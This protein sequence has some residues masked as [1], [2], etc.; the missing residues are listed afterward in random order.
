[1]YVYAVDNQRQPIKIWN[2]SYEGDRWRPYLPAL[3]P[4]VTDTEGRPFPGNPAEP[5][6]E[7]FVQC[8][9]ENKTLIVRVIDSCPCTQVRSDGRVT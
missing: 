5:Q 7:E 4:N 8:Y 9:D 2:G 1:M 3:N 6:G